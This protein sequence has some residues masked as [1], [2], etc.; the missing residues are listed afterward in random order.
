MRVL[1]VVVG[2]GGFALAGA[3]ATAATPVTGR[4]MDTE[5]ATIPRAHVLFYS[6]SLPY[7]APEAERETTR[8]TDM[9]G[10]YEAKLEPG[11][12]DLCVMA[13]PFDAICV[14][15]LVPKSGR[16]NH[17]VRLRLNSRMAKEID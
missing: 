10:Q 2:T 8:E 17:D 11:Y 14:K 5:G 1:S 13:P 3:L 9:A 6:N 7:T 4:V 16:L 15:V 12:Y